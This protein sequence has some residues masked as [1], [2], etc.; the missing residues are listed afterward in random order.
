MKPRIRIFVVAL[1]C[2]GSSRARR[3]RQTSMRTAA[4]E[5]ADR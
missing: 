2:A 4:R 3:F 1:F 5:A